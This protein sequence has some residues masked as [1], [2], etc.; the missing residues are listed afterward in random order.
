MAYEACEELIDLEDNFQLWRFRHLKTVE[1][2][3]GSK[4]GTGGSSAACRSCA[5]RWS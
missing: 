5:A 3:I 4:Q 1:R 2:I